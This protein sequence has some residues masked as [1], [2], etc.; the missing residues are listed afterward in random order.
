MVHCRTYDLLASGVNYRQNDS[1]K[2]N[3]QSHS[4]FLY[5]HAEILCLESPAP[6][7]GTVST[8]SA[9]N[10][11]NNYSLGS[12]ATFSCNSGFVLVG[13]TTRVCEDKNG[14]TVT[15][16]TW[17]GSEPICEGDKWSYV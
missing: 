12:V 17:S 16:G 2:S 15:T 1:R 8:V 6:E 7:N 11:H 13:Q 3:I 5:K 14:G 9:S 4:H 10:S